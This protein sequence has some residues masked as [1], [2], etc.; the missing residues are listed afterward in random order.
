[1]DLNQLVPP[2][3]LTAFSRDVPNPVAWILNRFLPDVQIP[4]IEAGIDRTIRRNRAA[5]FR[6]FDAET[7]I[8]ARNPFERSRVT[9]PPIS[10]KLP[11]GEE[12][13]LMLERVRNGGNGT[14]DRLVDQVYD[15]VTTLSG[16]IDARMELGRGDVLTDGKFTL[17]D[18]N[19]LTLEA[20]FG[21]P[22]D[23]LLAPAV[24][25]SDRANATPVTDLAAWADQYEEVNGERPGYVIMSRTARAHLVASAETR[26]LAGLNLVGGGG[27]GTVDNNQLAAIL[28]ARDLPQ[29]V[30][31]SAQIDVDGTATRPIP[32]DRVVMVPANGRDLGYTAWG[33]TAEAL[34][35]A[36]SN[37][38][39]LGF[40]QLPGKFA[41]TKK[42]FDPVKTWTKVSAVA[43]PLIEQPQR[44]L[45]A[46]VY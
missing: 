20:D 21:V 45:V 44:L 4:D 31:Y 22:A 19:G 29:I 14:A 42:D 24:L 17:Q 9:L 3:A 12:E 46:D 5:K 34:E 16:S 30:V 40:G 36:N 28:D 33:I 15:D 10:E 1:M 35:F 41:T 13:R 25:W 27:I 23:N 7:P 39:V 26:A 8:G 32:A 11:L 37:S 18:E 43:M 38:G 2:A 6:T